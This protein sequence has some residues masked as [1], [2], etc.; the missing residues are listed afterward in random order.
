MVFFLLTGDDKNGIM[1]FEV[2]AA[3]QGSQGGDRQLLAVHLVD[4][5]LP[6]VRQGAMKV[7]LQNKSHH[8]PAAGMQLRQRPVDQR[9]QVAAAAPIKIASALSAT[10]SG[11]TP[12]TIA[13]LSQPKRCRFS[14]SRRSASA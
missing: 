5:A 4:A 11:A 7:F 2:V 10:A 12:A 13:M 9:R 3:A 1:G 8:Q 6:Q 14:A